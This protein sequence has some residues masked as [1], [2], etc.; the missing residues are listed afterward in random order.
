[1]GMQRTVPGPDS[2]IREHAMMQTSALRP[3]K[4]PTEKHG[5]ESECRRAVGSG[6]PAP[7]SPAQRSGPE[8]VPCGPSH[9]Y[10]A[11]GS[12]PA[13]YLWPR[14]ASTAN[15]ALMQPG[16]P[17]LQHVPVRYATH[18]K[19]RFVPRQGF[20]EEEARAVG[21]DNSSSSAT[22]RLLCCTTAQPDRLMGK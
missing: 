6:A 1:M 14:S 7:H 9:I 2:L 19:R 13:S 17:P 12:T 8:S 3:Q 10:P 20:R 5:N 16:K 22:F 4:Q 11:L 18:G 15:Y 21:R